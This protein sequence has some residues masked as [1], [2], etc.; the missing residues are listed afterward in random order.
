MTAEDIYLI[1]DLSRASGISIY[2]IKFYLKLGLIKEV[3]RSQAT[4][5]RYFDNSTLNALK[6]IIGLRKDMSLAK[7]KTIL[8]AS[9][10][11]EKAL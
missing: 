2:T 1:K 6:E 8:D 5:F 9:A 4:N 10:K 3:G 7:I 11:K